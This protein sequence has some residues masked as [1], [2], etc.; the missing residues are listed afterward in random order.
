MG[1]IYQGRENCCPRGVPF[2]DLKH[3]RRL[4]LRREEQGSEGKWFGAEALSRMCFVR[5]NKFLLNLFLPRLLFGK[6]GSC[7]VSL[8]PASSYPQTY[9]WH[10]WLMSQRSSLLSCVAVRNV[11][12]RQTNDAQPRWQVILHYERIYCICA[13]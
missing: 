13:L 10:R 11:T 2:C 6:C 7:F 4:E 1:I 9:G 5:V 3:S 8:T 12:N